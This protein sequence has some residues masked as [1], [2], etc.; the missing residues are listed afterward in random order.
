MESL[1]GAQEVRR[2]FPGRILAVDDD[3]GNLAV[4]EGLLEDDYEVTALPSSV[5]A[6]EMVKERE[7]DMVISDQR[8]PQVTGVELLTEVHKNFPETV[9]IIVS[10]YSDSQEILACINQGHVYRYILKPWSPADMEAVVRQGLEYRFQRLAIRRLVDDLHRR[11]GELQSALTHLREAQ[12]QILH[13]AQLSTIGHLTSSIAHELKNQ[14]GSVRACYDLL[15]IDG[16]PDHLKELAQLGS[17]SVQTVL[18]IVKSINLYARRGSWDL[19]T[20]TQDLRKVLEDALLM[21][22][23]DNSARQRQWE[24]SIAPDLPPMGVDAVKLGQVIVNLLR[25]AMEATAAGG[26]VGLKAYAS[27]GSVFVEVS[28][29]GAG[30][31]RDQQEVVFEAF[32]T[33]KNRGVGLGLPISKQIVEAH[34]GKLWVN[35]EP[36]AGAIFTVELPIWS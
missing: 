8:M 14:L 30:I 15:Q 11:N 20:V 22:R 2:L 16:V 27:Q 23:M 32:Y 35:S 10:A 13:S 31:P 19:D 24:V 34:K 26:H 33:T 36:G 6:L 25:N 29:N 1:L 17:R 12:E 21:A 9:R 7:F 5:E 4:L 28:D 3:D 18:E